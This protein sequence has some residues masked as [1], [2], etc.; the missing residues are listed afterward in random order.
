M[1]RQRVLTAITVTVLAAITAGAL[2][3]TGSHAV[4]EVI[5]ASTWTYDVSNAERLRQWA[6][7]APADVSA[8]YL[9]AWKKIF[10]KKN[11]VQET[12]FDKHIRIIETAI[13]TDRSRSGL[14]TRK[15]NSPR[16]RE[17]FEVLYAIRVGWIELNHA[18]HL[19]IRRSGEER[20]L[21]V[22]EFIEEERNA[23]IPFQKVSP[24]IPIE[25]APMNF[26]D[27]V[28]MLKAINDDAKHL[29]PGWL[30]LHFKSPSHDVEEIADGGILLY[31]SGPIE[32]AAEW[33]V[34]GYL[35]LVSGKG[36]T[37]RVRCVER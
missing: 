22:V 18:D 15:G 35:N 23:E 21:T 34:E 20:Y 17:Y 33:G 24:F 3:L 30:A 9:P 6:W 27:S 2:Q 4:N 8:K 5:K 26:E 1:S 12:Y 32:N 37:R 7:E 19:V 16:G 10:L 31:G 14:A 29:R 11:D 36:A 28:H 25:H 13:T